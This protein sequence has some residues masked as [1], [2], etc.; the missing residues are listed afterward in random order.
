ME[1]FTEGTRFWAFLTQ[2]L[3]VTVSRIR[4]TVDVV[5]SYYLYCCSLWANYSRITSCFSYALRALRFVLFLRRHIELFELE[6]FAGYVSPLIGTD[7]FH[8]LSRRHYLSKN[9]RVG[10]R[11]GYVLEHYR[12]EQ[13]YF[14]VS[15]K[16]QVYSPSGLCLWKHIADGTEFAIQL[17]LAD[18][19]AAEGDLCV[20]LMV[21]GERLHA[22][23][24][25]WVRIRRSDGDKTAMYVGLNQG[26]WQRDQEYMEKFSLFFP[27]NSPN[28]ACYA[29]LQGVAQA[30]RINELLAVSSEFQVCSSP[31]KSDTFD[32]AYDWFWKAV[33]GVPDRTY[34]YALPIPWPIRDLRDVAS[35][36]RKRAAMRRVLL[37]N[38][39]NQTYACI[40]AHILNERTSD[41]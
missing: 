11:V 32:H 31:K 8:H 10:Q 38:I 7:K 35:K 26:R 1:N 13:D 3:P 22:I 9:L 18:R 6:V 17:A 30:A 23:S 5:S 21:D 33:G 16:R 41:S 34:G 24:F 25:S 40:A 28:F 14:D 29:A 36:H 39:C 4:S 37:E 20:R 12:F 19:Y 2:L 15:Y 27:H